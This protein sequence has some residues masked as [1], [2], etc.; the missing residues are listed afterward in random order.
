[1]AKF[2]VHSI[3]NIGEVHDTVIEAPDQMAIYNQLKEQ[4]ETLIS[5]EETIGKERQPFLRMSFGGKVK[6]RDK[7]IF[8]KNLSSMIDAGLSMSRA[9]MVIEKQTKQQKFKSIVSDITKSISQGHTLSESMKMHPDVF[10]TLMV[11]MVKAGEESGSLSQSLKS[12]STQMESSYQLTR[13]VKGAL[14]YPGIIMIAM[15]VIGFFMLTYVVPTLSSTF[16]E[17]HVDLPLSTR[18]IIGLSDFLKAHIFLSLIIMVGAFLGARFALKTK[19]GMRFMDFMVLHIPLISA[20]TQQIN[21]ARTART[22]SSLLTAGVD[23]VVAVRITKDVI[24]NSYYK[25]VLEVVEQKIEKGDPIATVFAQNEKLYPTFVSEMISVGE[26]TGQLAQMLLGV[27][28]YYET[29]VDQKT[30]DMSSIIEPF[31]MV[32]IGI[33]VGLFAI[34]MIMPIYSLGDHIN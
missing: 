8:A 16:K 9:L 14:M 4:N 5:A 27:A 32:F 17:L 1:M 21:A 23:V 11:S 10:P 34:S 22:F 13:K 26:E 29:E 7:I 3:T 33:V 25:S 20:M 2:K 28:A 15:V 19:K 18:I 24:Q 30:K 6:L 31:L 12:V